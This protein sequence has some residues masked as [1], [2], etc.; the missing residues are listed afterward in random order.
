MENSVF[1]ACEVLDKALLDA[2]RRG[3]HVHLNNS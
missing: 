1:Q 2:K 3:L